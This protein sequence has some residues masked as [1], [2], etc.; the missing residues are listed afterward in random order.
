MSAGYSR[1]IYA[2][3][4]GKYDRDLGLDGKN[5]PVIQNDRA[6]V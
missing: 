6:V 5:G 4:P 1:S 3:C 2:A